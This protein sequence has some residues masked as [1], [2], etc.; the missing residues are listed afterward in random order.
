MRTS[1]FGM[2]VRET[3]WP[4]LGNVY[5]PHAPRIRQRT[6]LY[7]TEAEIRREHPEAKRLDE[8]QTLRTLCRLP[9]DE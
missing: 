9:G 3:R 5:R 1:I 4:F 6:R 2:A 7:H 8:T